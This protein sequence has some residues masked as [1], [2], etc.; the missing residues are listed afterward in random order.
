MTHNLKIKKQ[1]AD[2]VVTGEKPFEVRINDRDYQTGDILRFTVVD[3][4]SKPIEHKLNEKQYVITYILPLEKFTP[5]NYVVLGIREAGE[6][7]EREEMK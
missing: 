3:I 7:D 1:Y 2:R 6:Q 4:A 5:I